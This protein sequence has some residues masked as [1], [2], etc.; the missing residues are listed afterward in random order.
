MFEY[1]VKNREPPS[2]TV[3]LV[4]VLGNI[5]KK[6]KFEIVVIRSETGS[7]NTTAINWN[8]KIIGNKKIIGISS[9]ILRKNA[10]KKDFFPSPKDV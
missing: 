5:E 3:I 4:F 7:A 10:K 8:E 2:P 9:K 6:I 1:K